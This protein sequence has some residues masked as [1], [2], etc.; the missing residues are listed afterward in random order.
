MKRELIISGSVEKCWACKGRG[1]SGSENHPECVVCSGYGWL[2]KGE[3]DAET[4]SR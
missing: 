3:E 2:P 4:P 1:Y